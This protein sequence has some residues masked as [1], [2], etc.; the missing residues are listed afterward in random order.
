[1]SM[2]RDE[3]EELQAKLAALDL[4]DDQRLLLDG[5]LRLAWD[6]VASQRSLDSEFD[7]C[8]EPEEADLIMAY[9]SATPTNSITRSIT[10]SGGSSSSITRAVRP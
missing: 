9:R 5:V 7:G 2:R 3:L 10:R 6:V 1:M 4:S 8:F